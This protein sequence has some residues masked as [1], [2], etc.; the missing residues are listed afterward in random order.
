MQTR[1]Q[2]L[3]LV[4]LNHRIVEPLQLEK[5]TKIQTINHVGW[6]EPQEITTSWQEN[7]LAHSSVCMLGC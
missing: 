4:T 2:I 1:R 3:P 7:A 6:K 5:I